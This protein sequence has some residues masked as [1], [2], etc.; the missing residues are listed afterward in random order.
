MV[1]QDGIEHIEKNEDNWVSVPEVSPCPQAGPRHPNRRVSAFIHCRTQ[2]RR[3][4][5]NGSGLKL[6]GFWPS[7][8]P[9]SNFLTFASRLSGFC[10]PHSS[11]LLWLGVIGLLGGCPRRQMQCLGW[12]SLGSLLFWLGPAPQGP[13]HKDLSFL[14]CNSHSALCGLWATRPL[15]THK[16]V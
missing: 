6:Q 4:N 9:G 12:V 2:I 3:C 15:D 16:L 5:L 14:G 8:P 7:L 1:L 13:P 10:P 11:P